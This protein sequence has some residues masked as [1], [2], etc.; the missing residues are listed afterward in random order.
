MGG[1]SRV[2]CGSE[3]ANGIIMSDAELKKHLNSMNEP[4]PLFLPGLKELP[5]ETA[6]HRLSAT[7]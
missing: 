7:S 3:L 6:R 5:A 2:R 1:A 4:R